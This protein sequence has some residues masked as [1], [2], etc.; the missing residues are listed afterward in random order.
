MRLRRG[1]LLLAAAMACAPAA[2]A[3]ELWPGAKY[4]PKIPT[5]KAV[6]GHDVGEEIS[7]PEEIVIYLKALAAAAP[8]RTRLV[9]YART[10]E[11][12]P[13]NLLIVGSPARIAALD[14]IK[15]DLQRLADPRAIDGSD[16][17]RLVASLP[18]VVWLMHAVHGNEISSSDAALA[19]AYHLLAA[20]NDPA[21]DEI[22][23]NALVLIDPLENPDGRARFIFQNRQGRAAVPDA[24]ACA[25]EH[26]E[27][28]PGG[29]TNHYLFDMNRDW[30]ARSQPETRGRAAD[31]ARATSRRSSSTCTRWAATHA[32]TSRRRPIRST[33]TSRRTQTKWLDTFGRANAARFDERGFAYFIREVYDSFYPGYGESWPIFQGAIGMTYEQASARGLVL[34]RDRRLDADV[35]RRRPAPLHFGA[36]P[37]ATRP[38]RTASS[39]C[40]TS[41]STAAPRSATARRP[42]CASTCWCRDPIRRWPRG[43]PTTSPA[44]A[45]TCA[46]RTSRSRSARVRC[47]AGAYLV[48]NAQPSGRLLRNLLEIDIKQPEAFVKEQ[49]RR[50]KKR[51]GDQIYD[52]TAWSLPA[53]F[54]V[55][56]RDE[57]A[58]A[59]REVDASRAADAR[60]R[61]AAAGRRRRSRTCCRGALAPRPRWP[62]PCAEGIKRAPGLGSLHASPVAPMPS[63]RPSCGRPTTATRWPRRSGASRR[64][65][66]RKS[67]RV[68]QRLGGFRH[69]ARHPATSCRSRRRE[70]CWPGTTRPTPC[71][72][73]GRATC[74]SAAMAL[75]VTAIRVSSLGRL[76]LHDADVLVLPQGN[77]SDFGDD[78]V[79]KLRE[80]V[81]GGGTLVTIGDASRWAATEQRGAARCAHRDARREAREQRRQ[82]Q[83]QGQQEGPGTGQAVRLR[84]GRPAGARA[85]REHA[86]RDAARAARSRA[87]AVVRHRRRDP[88]DGRRAARVHAGEARQ[89]QKRR[90]LREEGSARRRRAW[91][92]T[93]PAI[94]SPRRRT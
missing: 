86:W 3:Q 79:R 59:R 49:D 27:P 37:P 70:S 90:R 40:A 29:R 34:K 1:V 62:T 53:L 19:E 7:T 21:A 33:P 80:W 72:P 47:P 81:R 67:S 91:C 48:S 24:I 22:A 45:S 23:R 74:S 5:L 66:A 18:V 28:W 39:S 73:A 51:L 38:R 20:V 14:A 17:D 41:T 85:P 69:L 93:R 65:T 75:Q 64:R 15:A 58:G 8:E 10:W 68:E 71:R 35:S 16:A 30:F 44:R 56:V 4:D 43:W 9:E 61:A 54:D 88:G 92:G 46:A 42:R 89:G 63:A 25:A 87:L 13:L 78:M 84:Q 32:T 26:D 94:S 77:Y 57:R 50:R 83:G 55:D 60:R 82:G 2:R 12:R 31:L 11:G 76:D 36:S 6:L 52:V